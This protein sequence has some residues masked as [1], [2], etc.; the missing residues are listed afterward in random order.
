MGAMERT[1]KTVLLV[2][3]VDDIKIILALGLQHFGYKVVTASNT[4]EALHL[5]HHCSIDAVLTD[6]WM[7]DTN[8][9]SVPQAIRSNERYKLIPIALLSVS[10]MCANPVS[11]NL[12]DFILEKPFSLETVVETVDQMCFAELRI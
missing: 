5:L 9:Q 4:C 10:G 7:P 11:E 6:L 1:A 8:G 12:F 3:D 2:D